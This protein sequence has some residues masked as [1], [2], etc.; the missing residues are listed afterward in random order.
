ML[1][2]IMR[3]RL[4]LPFSLSLKEKRSPLKS[5]IANLQNRFKCSVAEVDDHDLHQVTT[6]GISFVATDQAIYDRQKTAIQKH[7]ETNRDFS[8]LEIKSR[9]I[10]ANKHNT[11]SDE[12][13]GVQ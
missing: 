12:Y 7:L 2:G 5:L 13:T 6:I 3:I 1:V 8:V 10:N 4:H 11:E 9:R